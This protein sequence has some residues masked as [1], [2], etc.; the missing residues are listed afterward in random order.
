MMTLVIL[1]SSLLMIVIG[2]VLLKAHG[3]AL[4]GIGALF[5]AS[6]FAQRACV[7]DGSGSLCLGLGPGLS[8]ALF[9]FALVF[10]VP[11]VLK[12]ALRMRRQG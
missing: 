6:G 1:A 7:P 8:P 12:L 5:A 11:G 4:L 9:A 3:V 10:L 2:M